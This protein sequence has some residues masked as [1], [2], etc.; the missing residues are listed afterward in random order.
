MAVGGV[1]RGGIVAASRF[2]IEQDGGDDGLQISPLPRSEAY[3]RTAEHAAIERCCDA[4]HIRGAGVAGH[5]VLNQLLANK[6]RQARLR[7]NIVERA[8]QIRRRVLPSW[9]RYG[10]AVDR[11]QRLRGGVVIGVERFHGS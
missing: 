1:C 11:Q 7:E 10:G 5:Q 9:K 4:L 3:S 6:R 2:R 8:L